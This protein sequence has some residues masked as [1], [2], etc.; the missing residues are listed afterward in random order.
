MQE[1]ERAPWLRRTAVSGL[2]LEF[3][4]LAIPLLVERDGGLAPPVGERVEAFAGDVAGVVLRGELRLRATA[5]DLWLQAEPP[6]AGERGSP[7]RLILTMPDHPM[8]PV[9]PPLRELEPGRFA[10]A[11]ELPMAGRWRLQI[12]LAGET[13]E[14]LF[15][16]PP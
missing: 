13:L 6:A 9:V 3:G 5:F 1:P 12:E 7:P 11:G 2:R 10:A 8:E 16:A 15:D 4:S 14:L